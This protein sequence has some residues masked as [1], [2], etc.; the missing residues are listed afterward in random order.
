MPIQRT[1]LTG[2]VKN[3]NTVSGL[4]S[5]CTSRST[6]SS[7]LVPASTLLPFL[8]LRLTLELLQAEAPET[9]YE[10]LELFQPLGTCAVEPPRPLTP[11]AHETGLLEYAQVLRDGGAGH[12]E[13]RCDRASGQLAV[14]DQL[15]DL[16]SPRFRKRLD[17]RLHAQ[18]M[19]R[20]R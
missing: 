7:W 1:A 3:S 17:G 19:L 16:A 4:A 8:G 14:A 10:F 11:L 2:L 12:V 13:A 6:T 20:A 18:R 15:E 9:F 5:I